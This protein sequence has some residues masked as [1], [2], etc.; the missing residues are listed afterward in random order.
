MSPSPQLVW[1]PSL[2]AAGEE[3]SFDA[4]FDGIRRI[5]LDGTSWVD[6][7][8]GWVSG[9]DQLFERLLADMGWQQRS[10]HMYEQRVVEP[11]LTAH[12]NENMATPLDPPILEAMR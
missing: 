12:W 1:Q 2:F 11:R 10:R 6:H 4:S 3:T 8:P 9:S 5:R 7:Q